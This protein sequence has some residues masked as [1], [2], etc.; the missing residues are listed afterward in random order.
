MQLQQT[1]R[2]YMKLK[3]CDR[4]FCLDSQFIKP[5][6]RVSVVKR[7]DK[8]LN[9]RYLVQLINYGRHNDILY[10]IEKLFFPMC[11]HRG[12]YTLL[13]IIFKFWIFFFFFIS[14]T[15]LDRDLLF[16]TYTQHVLTKGRLSQNFCLGLSFYFM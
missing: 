8:R 11:S 6:I 1:I 12:K 4:W 16:E 3:M 15:I 7:T 9:V 14:I 5:C 2:S 10:L 13:Y